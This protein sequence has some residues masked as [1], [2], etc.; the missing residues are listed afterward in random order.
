MVNNISS[1]LNAYQQALSRIGGNVPAEQPKPTINN[2]FQ[3]MVKS[4]VED[5]V[6][7]SKAHLTQIFIQARGFAAD[8]LERELHDR[9]PAE[10]MPQVLS[11]PADGF[12]MTSKGIEIFL[13]C[14]CCVDDAGNGDGGAHEKSIQFNGCLDCVGVIFL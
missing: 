6:D 13:R 10:T 12:G 11:K 14:R 5:A 1:A 8:I 2:E 9:L 7:L 3:N 4:A